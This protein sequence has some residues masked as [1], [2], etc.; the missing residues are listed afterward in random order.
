MSFTVPLPPRTQ[1]YN[2][3]CSNKHTHTHVP[4]SG[5]LPALTPSPLKRF[6]FHRGR[7]AGLWGRGGECLAPGGALRW[8][9]CR[10][11]FRVCELETRPGLRGKQEEPSME[12][13]LSVRGHFRVRARALRLM[14]HTLRLSVFGERVLEVGSTSK[15][16]ARG[17]DRNGAGMRVAEGERAR[18]A[19]GPAII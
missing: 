16:R 10:G 5:S 2:R 19:D 12:E 3:S 14:S 11:L 13:P 9:D 1:L 8:I 7:P 4:R 18:G 6:P 17:C 15:A